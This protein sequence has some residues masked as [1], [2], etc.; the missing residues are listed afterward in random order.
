MKK[1]IS[2]FLAIVITGYLAVLQLIM[3]STSPILT[4]INTGKQKINIEL[5]RSYS[6]E[7]DCPIILPIQDIAVKGYLIYNFKSD[8]LKYQRDSVKQERDSVKLERIN[9]KR[10]GDKL[11]G[12]IPGQIPSTEMEYRVFLEREKTEIVVNNSKPVLLKFKGQV[13]FY[14]IF[15]NGFLVVLVLLLSNLTGIFAVFG[16]KSY[17]WM[18][19]LTVIAFLFLGFFI[20]PLVQKYSLNIWSSLPKTWNLNS[21]IF[22]GSLVW[23]IALLFSLKK[24]YR[25][26]PIFA[27]L[28]SIA[29]FLIPHQTAGEEPVKITFSILERNFIALLQ[30][31]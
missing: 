15:L 11:I 31:F 7:S 28:I 16:I 26:W 21:K 2:W 14:L 6:G 5:I 10:E 24:S 30:L 23:L 1:E 13:P 12:F 17:K 18:I 8:S 3:G 20:S 19:F 4:E 9:L 29:I 25:I 22:S 27:T